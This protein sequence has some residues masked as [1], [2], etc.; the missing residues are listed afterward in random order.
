MKFLII[1]V[2]CSSLLLEGCYS[3]YAVNEEDKHQHHPKEDES[4]LV[5]LKDGSTIESEAY[6]HDEVSEPSDLVYVVAGE[7]FDMKTGERRRFNGSIQ[8][9][10][11][12]SNDGDTVFMG[13]SALLPKMREDECRFRLSDSSEVRCQKSDCFT[14]TSKEGAGLWCTGRMESKNSSS[15]FIGM[16]AYENI[17]QI[18]VKEPSVG[19]TLL[20]TGG[21]VTGVAL[22]FGTVVALSFAK[23]FGSWG[24]K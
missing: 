4:I 24:G 16:T 15:P 8:P 10:T 19:K 9:M 14:V 22:V 5:T 13:G 6:H 3:Y 11:F 2:L 21:I 23:S 1:I 17:K 12:P 18:E 7:R 20:L